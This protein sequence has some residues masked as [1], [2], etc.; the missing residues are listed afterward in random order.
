MDVPPLSVAD[1]PLIME[2]KEKSHFSFSPSDNSRMNYS[3]VH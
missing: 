1:K 3:E 2:E